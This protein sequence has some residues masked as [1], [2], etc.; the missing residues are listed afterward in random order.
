[1]G[2]RKFVAP[3]FEDLVKQGDWGRPIA[4]RI[5]AKAG[6]TYHSVTAGT[7]EKILKGGGA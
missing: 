4:N 7:V 6:P 5:Y 2:R 1:M 3:L